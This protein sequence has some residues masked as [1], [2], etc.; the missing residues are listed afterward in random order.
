LTQI[1]RMASEEVRRIRREFHVFL[2]DTCGITRRQSMEANVT[3][4]CHIFK[5]VIYITREAADDLVT[6]IR[7][8]VFEW[9]GSAMMD[10]CQP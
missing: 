8:R 5:G 6:Q 9:D 1:G 4:R 10:R 2:A 3:D 7:L